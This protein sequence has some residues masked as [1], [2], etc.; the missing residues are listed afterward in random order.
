VLAQLTQ[1]NGVEN[2]FTDEES[3]VIRVNLRPGADPAR[4]AREAQAILSAR[5]ADRAP[6]RLGRQASV[7]AL[8]GKSWWDNSRITESLAAKEAATSRPPSGGIAG[9]LWLCLA[10]ALGLV[11]WW[12]RRRLAAL[13][14][15]PTGMTPRP[16]AAQ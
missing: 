7:A 14:L 8:P 15:P 13:F 4:V 9:L 16:G 3:T 1:I 6:V 11:G 12:Q 2:S 10:I 5:V